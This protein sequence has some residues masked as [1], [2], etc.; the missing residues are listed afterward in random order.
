[1]YYPNDTRLSSR[2]TAGYWPQ[3]RACLRLC[4]VLLLGCVLSAC[5][6]SG[7]A[8][9]AALVEARPLELFY[10]TTRAPAPNQRN[11][12]GRDRGELSYGIAEVAI[13][14]NHVI[15]RNE[16]P[17]VFRFE[18][19]ENERKHIAL[20]GTRALE[21]AD[22]TE[23]LNAAVMQSPNRKLMVFVHG[24]NVDFAQAARGLAQFATDLKFDG[25][26]LLFSWPSQSSLMG[27]AADANNVEWSQTHL[28]T[29][30]E[31]IVDRTDVEQIYLFGHS[32]G[33][34][35]LTRAH[36]NLASSRPL[37]VYKVRQLILV[38]PD[39]DADLFRQDIAPRLART[40]T[41]VTLYASSGDRALAASKTF[42][43]HPRAGDSGRGL[44]VVPGVETVDVSGASRG[45]TGHTY[46]SEDRRIMEDIYAILTTSQSSDMRFGLQ[47]VEIPEGR[48]WT[49]RR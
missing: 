32:M 41:P 11:F 13:P 25:P 6:S 43:G 5:G 26:V 38:A 37:D 18:W 42:N 46:F 30:L 21:N 9:S 39:I 23:Q 8:R 19:S 34:R 2:R 49:F 48:Y 47:V 4:L 24:F 40:H 36:L 35:A 10:A 15:G 27:Y 7:G 20:R 22:F 28:T 44:V 45:F 29:V 17:S 14:P 31:E 16:Q 3:V 33:G 1:M 12:F